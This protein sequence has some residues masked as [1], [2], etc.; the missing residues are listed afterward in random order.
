MRMVRRGEK[1]RVDVFPV[2]HLIVV[3]V[4][5]AALAVLLPDQLEGRSQA[6][7]AAIIEHAIVADL[8]DVAEGSDVDVR[9]VEE[10]LHVNNAL[11][12]CADDGDVDLFA[13]GSVA[14]AA[15]YMARYD[16]EGR[17]RGGSAEEIPPRNH[18][19]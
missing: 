4:S 6:G 3:V 11:A 13:G 15:E 9:L 18:L 16:A 10:L 14:V 17:G 19:L 2:E 1:N 5:W 7:C 12:A 8:V